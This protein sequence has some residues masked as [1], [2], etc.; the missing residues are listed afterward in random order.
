M[1][2]VSETVESVCVSAPLAK[3]LATLDKQCRLDQIDWPEANSSWEILW[4][5]GE[6]YAQ[7]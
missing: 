2:Y 4:P 5:A 7:D 3:P 1:L 6:K